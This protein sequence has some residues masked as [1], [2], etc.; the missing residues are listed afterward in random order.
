MLN[1]LKSVLF[2]I[3]FLAM[4]SLASQGIFT[5]WDGTYFYKYAGMVES[6]DRFE[7]TIKGSGL[8]PLR[9]PRADEIVV[10]EATDLNKEIH[11]PFAKSE[12]TFTP[13]GTSGHCEKTG[14]ILWDS[15]FISRSFDNL[16]QQ[17]GV[18]TSLP[19]L[20]VTVDFSPTN[21]QATFQDA[22][23]NPAQTVQFGLEQCYDPT[24]NVIEFPEALITYL[25]QLDTQK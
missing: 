7:L 13:D 3:I 22:S 9:F 23:G 18:I 24:T 10:I 2:N 25:D 17:V 21:I 1:G 20:K 8:G 15:L 5:C 6:A 11:M 12:C 4:P 14:N 19:T 16:G